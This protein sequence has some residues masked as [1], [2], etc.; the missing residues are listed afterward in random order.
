MNTFISLKDA[1]SVWVWREVTIIFLIFSQELCGPYVFIIFLIL[2]IF[3]F[4]FTF[5]RVPETKGRTFDDIAQG[6]SASAAKSP[7]S[8]GPEAVVVGLPE[9]KDVPPMSPTEKVPMVDLPENPWASFTRGRKRVQDRW[10]FPTTKILKGAVGGCLE[11]AN[12]V[13]QCRNTI[14][15]FLVCLF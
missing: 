5:L 15:S 7:Q 11:K 4:V 10:Q 2:L 9:S 3:F 13:C 12:S 6:F 14:F 1:E 8:P